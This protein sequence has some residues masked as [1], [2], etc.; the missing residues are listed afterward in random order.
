MHRLLAAALLSALA[1]PAAAYPLFF[2][3]V[4]DGPSEAASLLGGVCYAVALLLVVGDEVRRR[5]RGR[6]DVMPGP[7]HEVRPA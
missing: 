1:L 2:A 7:S 4:P 3:V 5:R 6:A